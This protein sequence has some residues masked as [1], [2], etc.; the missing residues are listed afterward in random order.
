[1]GSHTVRAVTESGHDVRLLVRSKERVGPALDPLE[2][3]PPPVMIGDATNP[4][5]VRAA[6]DG[7]DAVIHCAA[8]FSYHPRNAATMAAT[9]HRAAEVVLRNALEAGC[10][11]VVYCSSVAAL[12]PIRMPTVTPQT[13]LGDSGG[14]YVRSKAEAEAFVRGLQAEGGPVVSVLP[15]G[16]AGPH[17]PY[18]GETNENW[19]RRPLLGLF[20]FRIARGSLLMVDVREVAAVFAASL[21]PGRGPRT[22]VAG[23]PIT[24]NGAFEMMRGLTGRR[25]RQFPVPTP[26]ARATGR[27]FSTIA[28]L[29]IPPLFTYEG[30]SVILTKWPPT[31]ESALRDDLGVAEIP[32][33]TSYADTIRW[34]V[35]V[36][37]LRPRHAG[38][39]VH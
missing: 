21:S 20:P 34:M 28:R 32:L 15:G 27:A 25:L 3:D 24:W 16:V 22:Y 30:L 31:D 6:L 12:I 33:E 10:D 2:I 8:V 7:C 14:A 1:M 18:V 13:P 39:L 23:R 38:A 4:Q 26:L 17:D 37:H 19:I 11:P 5:A 35:E 29:G 36:G 9:N